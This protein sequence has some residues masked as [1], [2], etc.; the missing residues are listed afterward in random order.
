MGTKF[1]LSQILED[2]ESTSTLEE[3]ATILIQLRDTLRIDHVTYHWVDGAG[4]QYGF[5]TYS[6]AWDKQYRDKNYHR[7]DPV[8]LGCFQRFHAVDWKQLNW[9]G[10]A[11]RAF[12][13]DAQD[14]GVGNQ[15]YSIPLRGPS[16]QFALFT[17]N[18]TCD[19]AAWQTFKDAHG[20]DLILVAHFL[21]RKALEFAKNRQPETTRGLSPRE[22]DA[23]TL[24]AL[25]YSRAQVAHSLSISEHTLRAYIESARSKLGAQNTT[26]AIATA[27]SRGLIVV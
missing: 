6:D 7:I 12:L 14:H 21:N 26:H 15:G 22:I 8:I 17:V 27:L 3:L 10:K 1:D 9:S 16:G 20:R 24:L 23:M 25:G 18:N 11:V 5:T 19:D 2:L 13:E 4:D